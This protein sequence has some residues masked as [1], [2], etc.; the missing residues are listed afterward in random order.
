MKLGMNYKHYASRQLG[1]GV[2]IVAF[3]IIGAIFLLP[4]ATKS[5]SAF[6]YVIILGGLF[7][8]VPATLGFE[9]ILAQL[10]LRKNLYGG[11]KR[12]T[13]PLHKAPSFLEFLH[14]TL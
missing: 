8:A 7:V 9:I 2:F 6:L 1:V 11:K 14:Y 13:D 10:K 5:S 3:A 4:G 12:Q